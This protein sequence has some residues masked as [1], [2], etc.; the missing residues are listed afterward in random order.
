MNSSEEEQRDPERPG[1]DVPPRSEGAQQPPEESVPS[2]RERSAPG[3]LRGFL[4]ETTIVLGIALVLSILLKTFL[5]Q[6]FYIPSESMQPTLEVGDRLIVNKLRASEEKLD[7]GDIVV[8][9]DPG[10]WLRPQTVEPTAVQKALTWVGLLPENANEHLI[11]RIIGMPG[12][13]VECCDEQGRILVN[14]AAI[15]EPY[16]FAGVAPSEKEFSVTVPSAHLWLLGDNRPRS[17]DSRYSEGAVGGGFVPVRNVVGSAWLI[18]W[19][20]DRATVLSNP[21]AT[22]ADV[23]AP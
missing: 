8:F 15:D 7:R 19:P 5:I 17:Q 22:F 20:F 13:T 10:G 4:K 3:G 9:V 6:A 2:P 21:H 12:D 14:G 1:E 16:I 23:P 18:M 11:K